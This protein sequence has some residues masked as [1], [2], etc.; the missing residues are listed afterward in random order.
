ML[1]P[2]LLARPNTLQEAFDLLDDD[3]VIPYCGGTELLLAMRAGLLRPKVLVDLKSVPELGGVRLEGLRLAIGAT[4]KH[5]EL[6][7]HP[8]VREHAPYLSDVERRVGNPRVR[9]QGSIG[10]NLGFGEPRSDLLTA[11]IALKAS[12]KL[13]GKHT[14]RE[15]TAAE[16][17]EGQY[18]TV[19]E[20]GEVLESVS[21]LLPLR[22]IAVYTKYQVFERPTVA[23]AAVGDETSI[24][25]V[26][27][28]AG[29][30]PV[31]G[32]FPSGEVDVASLVAAVDPIDDLSGST[33]YKRSMAEVYVRIALDK[34][35][36]KAARP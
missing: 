4:T 32:D 18:A 36:E 20:N 5:A 24:R 28:A 1:P 19:L 7:R 35:L 15:V 31:Y 34:Y 9:A 17:L 10:G 23:V 14:A 16:F 21:I 11:L 27:G 12:V 2:F 8:L 26:I 3:D 29:E 30:V 25:V 6:I 33:K 13:R 22:P